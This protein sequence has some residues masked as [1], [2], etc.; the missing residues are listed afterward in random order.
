MKLE[1]SVLVN[2]LVV[3]A[4]VGSVGALLLTRNIAT[5]EERDARVNNLCAECSQAPIEW[6]RIQK[7]ATDFTLQQHT[8]G[9]AGQREFNLKGQ[10]AADSEASQGL[11]RALEV[12]SFVRRFD[13]N[14]V[15]RKAFGLASPRAKLSV[16]LSET[17]LNIHVGNTA[18][19]SG[20]SYV[21]VSSRLGTNVGLVKDSTLKELL[22]D[23]EQLREKTLLALAVSELDEIT[24]KD[25]GHDV[26]VRRGQGPSWINRQGERVARD[27]VERLGYE[28]FAIKAERFLS[29]AEAKAA[30]AAGG[31][32]DASFA[33]KGTPPVTIRVGGECP[34]DKALSVLLRN[35]PNPAAACIA[36]GTRQ[37][38]WNA[39]SNLENNALFDLHVDEVESLRIERG[40]RKLEL[41]R[42]ERG[43]TLRAP[44]HADVTLDAG[45]QRIR[46]L[47]TEGMRL[48]Q[49][50]LGSLGLT[51]PSGK[52]TLHSTSLRE[53]KSYDEVLEIGRARLDGSLPVRRV[54][55]GVVLELNREAARAFE[56]DSTLLRSNKLLD[57]GPSELVALDVSWG[58]ERQILRRSGPGSFEL[59][60]P[61]SAHDASLALD[62][63]QALGTLTAERWVADTDDGSFGFERPRVRASLELTPG[64]A[65]ARNYT[66]LL[67]SDTPGGVYAKFAHQA[68]VFVLDRELM[69][70]LTTLLLTRS[71]F[72]SDPNN[73]ERVELSRRGKRLVLAQRGSE[74]RVVEG[75]Q[76]TPELVSELSETLGSLRPE[77]A[78]HTGPPLPNEGFD[79][80]LLQV[81]VTAKVGLGVSKAFRIGA[82]DSFRETSI[83]YA[84]ADGIDATYAIAQSALRPL[85]EVF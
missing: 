41:V 55:D 12:A 18:G 54:E 4:A 58:R 34:A 42:N 32:L 73:I 67:G 19:A 33:R 81:R 74:L 44:S 61:A 2:A 80:P 23:V 64:D 53:T 1:R 7:N 75:P 65:G 25:A 22:V 43:F 78:V 24:F 6:I 59:A 46:A 17:E 29:V 27:A 10:G 45:N 49:P 85:L 39:A 3:V 71:A 30:L 83:F 5:T 20:Q 13:A 28:L 52:V 72:A 26:A 56:I 8:R 37:L 70:T 15:D 36:G 11:V 47:L 9:D 35:Q 38:F 57:F 62:L 21:E 51:L 16:R 84:R 79:S 48:P 76:L 14:A 69:G 31:A 63:V 60:T 77:A 68:G 50:D 40:D 82:G 66:L